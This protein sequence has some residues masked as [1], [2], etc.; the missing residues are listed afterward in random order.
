[1]RFI[2]KIMS[3]VLFV[4][5]ITAASVCQDLQN[6]IYND[7]L[8]TKTKTQ[9]IKPTFNWNNIPW[10][11]KRLGNPK[12]TKLSNGGL[13]YAWDCGNRLSDAL[14]ISTDQNGKV[15]RVR[16]EFNTN[17]GAGLFDSA[18]S[19]APMDAA[20][21]TKT[22]APQITNK[23]PN[24]TQDIGGSN[25]QVVTEASAS[26]SSSSSVA[27]D[28]INVLGLVTDTQVQIAQSEN[29]DFSKLAPA[30]ADAPWGGTINIMPT[31]TGFKYDMPAPSAELCAAITAELNN[32]KQYSINQDCSEIIYTAK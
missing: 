19:S 18:H 22:I 16:G 14:I 29:N 9:F 5:S 3:L 2:H 4:P 6:K 10:L 21:P 12:V 20:T 23:L 11:K 30:T 17:K 24:S 28:F 8:T 13:E 15:I 26:S 25:N 31:Q 1:M 32:K 27:K 7:L